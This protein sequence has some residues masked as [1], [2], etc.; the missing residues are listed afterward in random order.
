VHNPQIHLHL[1]QQN[2]LRCAHRFNHQS[3]LVYNL[4]L[5]HLQTLASSQ[6]RN[7][8]NNLSLFR[9][10]NHRTNLQSNPLTNH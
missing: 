5:Y 10:S 6:P 9:Q 8:R 1:N 3:N 4:H 2:N 7:P